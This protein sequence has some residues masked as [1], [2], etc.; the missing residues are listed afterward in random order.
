MLSAPAWGLGLRASS[1]S[2]PERREVQERSQG[3]EAGKGA[4]GAEARERREGTV[5]R[6]GPACRAL[7]ARHVWLQAPVVA[8]VRGLSRARVSRAVC[9]C[10]RGRAPRRP[11]APCSLPRAAV[12]VRLLLLCAERQE[13]HENDPLSELQHQIAQPGDEMHHPAA[14]RLGDLLPHPGAGAREWTTRRA[15]DSGASTGGRARG[16]KE[17]IRGPTR[18]ADFSSSALSLGALLRDGVE[19]TVSHRHRACIINSRGPFLWL[20]H[21]AHVSLRLG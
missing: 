5:E 15:W 11:R 1:A 14:G 18:K 9:V 16:D 4:G 21:C 13:D 20:R 10:P 17:P 6:E 19:G 7:A 12:H 8:A 3:A 2:E